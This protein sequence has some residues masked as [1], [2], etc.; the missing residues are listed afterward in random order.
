MPVCLE[1]GRVDGRSI[2]LPPPLDFDG[3][4]PKPP[5]SI[6]FID[7]PP[8]E[9]P[10]VLLPPMSVGFVPL[11]TGTLVPEDVTDEA[12]A[13]RGADLAAGAGA[14]LAVG[15]AAGAGFAAAADAGADFDDGDDF[16][17]ADFDGAGAASLVDFDFFSGMGR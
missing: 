7:P 9:P 11:A 12:G 16:G 13:A 6:E 17:A 5:P 10:E 2:C 4:P 3:T 15:F 1:F 8:S 14:G